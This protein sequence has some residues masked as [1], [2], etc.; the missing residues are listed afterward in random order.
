MACVW[1]FWSGMDSSPVIDFLPY[2]GEKEQTVNNPIF[3]FIWRFWVN[4]LLGNYLFVLRKA[5]RWRFHYKMN[6]WI[7][8]L[9]T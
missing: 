7:K 9:Q 6:T 8:E 4:W 2:W 5:L 1:H 3:F